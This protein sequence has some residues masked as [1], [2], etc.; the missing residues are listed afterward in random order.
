MVQTTDADGHDDLGVNLATRTSSEAQQQGVRD[1]PAIIE[2]QAGTEMKIPLFP[3]SMKYL[4]HNSKSA[5]TGTSIAETRLNM[6]PSNAVLTFCL[7]RI[8]LDL[9][10]V[11]DNGTLITDLD[12]ECPHLTEPIHFLEPNFVMSAASENSRGHFFTR[13]KFPSEV[14][15]KNEDVLRILVA[16]EDCEFKVRA[17]HF[18]DAL[19]IGQLR[20]DAFKVFH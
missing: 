10:Y 9:N 3:A 19:L 6:S 5:T 4:L 12:I 7:D 11:L 13:G 15:L 14:H 16:G 2:C 20:G 8:Y 18:D 1:R 17:Y